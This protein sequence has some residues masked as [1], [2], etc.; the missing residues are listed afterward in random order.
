[1]ADTTRE[2]GYLRVRNAIRSRRF[3]K[4]VSRCANGYRPSA[5]VSCQTEINDGSTIHSQ[6]SGRLLAKRHKA[7]STLGHGFK[8]LSAEK[9]VSC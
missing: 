3:S 5:G 1:M 9:W 2:K 8:K 6:T 7:V 4:L